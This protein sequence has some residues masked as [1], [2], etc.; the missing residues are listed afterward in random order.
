MRVRKRGQVTTTA[1]KSK[2]VRFSFFC[3][4]KREREIE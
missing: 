1:T 3:A 2:K 4:T